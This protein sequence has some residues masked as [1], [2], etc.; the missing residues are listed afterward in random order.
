M[1]EFHDRKSDRA[2]LASEAM[3]EQVLPSVTVTVFVQVETYVAAGAA[4]V[5]DEIVLPG[6]STHK[7][8]PTA[9]LEQ[10]ESTNGFHRSRSASKRLFLDKRAEQVSPLA[11]V[12]VRVQVEMYLGVT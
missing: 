11:M 5:L 8:S 4:L 1:S 10:T 2:T 6:A 12:A 9:R 3:V 7:T